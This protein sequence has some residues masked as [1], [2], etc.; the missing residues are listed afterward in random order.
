[1]GN[2]LQLPLIL[3]GNL[4]VIFLVLRVLGRYFKS[5]EL[6]TKRAFEPKSLVGSMQVA[7]QE[8]GD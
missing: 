2:W 8:S 1:V 6:R 7:P 4:V 3:A 5:D